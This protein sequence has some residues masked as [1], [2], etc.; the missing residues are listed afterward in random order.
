MVDRYIFNV[1]CEGGMT[2][3]DYEEFMAQEDKSF[4]DYC[5]KRDQCDNWMK[6]EEQSK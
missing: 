6:N 2:Q 4:C 5:Y 1:F 3:K